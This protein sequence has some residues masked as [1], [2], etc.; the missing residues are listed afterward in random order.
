METFPKN[1]IKKENGKEYIFS[2]DDII[3]KRPLGEGGF[4]EVYEVEIK[5]G[6]R[7]FKYAIKVYKGGSLEYKKAKALKAYENYL[8]CKEAG[9]NVFQVVRISEDG[10]QLLMTLAS[11]DDFSVIDPHTK[12]A[13][14]RVKHLDALPNLIYQLEENIFRATEKNIILPADSYLFITQ[15]TNPN[16]P[17]SVVGDYDSITISNGSQ[18][19]IFETNITKAEAALSDFIRVYV[20]REEI[21]ALSEYIEKKFE[22]FRKMHGK[23]FS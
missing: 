14:D 3:K 5:K 23:R 6:S 22:N 17:E 12:V 21:E 11:D 15:K 2:A 18:K 19:D 20:E 13:F 4:G 9:I 16:G 7:F 8:L 10:T 1:F